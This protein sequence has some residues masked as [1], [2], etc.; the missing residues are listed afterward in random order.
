MSQVLVRVRSN[1]GAS[2]A[3]ELEITRLGEVAR[4]LDGIVPFLQ[5]ADHEMLACTL[6]LTRGTVTGVEWVFTEPM[7]DEA[8]RLDASLGSNSGRP[9]TY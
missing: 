7:L 2:P 6:H 1:G 3:T 8:R 9:M 5:L 4:L